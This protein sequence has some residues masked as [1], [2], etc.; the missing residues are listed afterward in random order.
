MSSMNRGDAIVVGTT[1]G[2][3]SGG[4]VMSIDVRSDVFND[5]RLQREPC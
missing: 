5:N 4:A 2:P 3:P 1:D